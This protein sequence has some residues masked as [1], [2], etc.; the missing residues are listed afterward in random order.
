MGSWKGSFKGLVFRV[1]FWAYAR[2]RLSR[3]VMA[4]LRVA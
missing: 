2:I 3:N 4:A 1:P